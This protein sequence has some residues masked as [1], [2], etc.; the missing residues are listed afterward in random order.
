MPREMN[1]PAVTGCGNATTVIQPGTRIEVDGD[2][3]LVMALE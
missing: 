1:V 3:S 2:L